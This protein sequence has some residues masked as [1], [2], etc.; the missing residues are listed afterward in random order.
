MKTVARSGGLLSR[1][2]SA[3]WSPAAPVQAPNDGRQIRSTPY[4]SAFLQLPDKLTPRQV[5]Q[6]LRAALAGD[7]MQMN[8]L[9]N[10]MMRSW[11]MLRKC[12]HELRE[13]CSNTRFVV[14]PYSV[15]KGEAPT[16]SA[17]DKADLIRRAMA[18]FAPAQDDSNERGWNG[19]IYDAG[20]AM[21][22]GI[23]T[24]ELL[25]HPPM[26]WGAG[27]EKLPRAAC[28]ANPRHFTFTSDGK[29]LLATPSVGVNTFAEFTNSQTAGKSLDPKS[30]VVG[31]FKS[32]SGSVLAEGF[33]APLALYWAAMKF[34][35]EPMLIAAQN[36]GAPYVD[37]T[38]AQGMSLDQIN[39]LIDNIEKGLSNRVIAH[40]EGSVVTMS[41]GAHAASQNPQMDIVKLSDQYCCELLL[42]TEATT[43]KST[44]TMNGD[45]QN[46]PQDK[47]KNER[48]RGLANWCS[49]EFLPHFV[50][51]VL[52]QNY[53]TTA[54]ALVEKPTIEPDFTQPLTAQ[55]KGM[56]MT[57]LAN[58]K[59]PL[60]IEDYYDMVGA[61]VPEEG[62]KVIN[63]STGEIG[64]IGSTEED[65]DVSQVQPP[66][67]P[68]PVK[69]DENN[70]PIPAM[71]PEQAHGVPP[72]QATIRAGAPFGNDNA[73]KNHIHEGTG[74]PLNSDGTV[75]LYHGTTAAGEKAIKSDGGL[76]GKEDGVFLTTH[77][78]SIGYGDKVVSVK[79][80]P[81]KLVLDDEFPDGRKDFRIPAKVGQLVP[82]K[83]TSST[84]LRLPINRILAKATPEEVGQIIPILNAAEIA[85]HRNGE[86]AELTKKLLEIQNR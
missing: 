6:I 48:V 26:D 81:S 79:V 14:K 85:V 60:T 73:A 23:S 47:T 24:T 30:F 39:N 25:F 35:Y 38:H 21:L 61:S 4:D 74:L 53:G 78:D 63:P 11:P 67:P 57:A 59:T 45:S 41:P 64:L 75:T 54:A 36:F 29:L 33:I 9:S 17:L 34:C 28:W 18:N 72:V 27:I 44:N 43:K 84:P 62:D 52:Y 8:R 83:L 65:Y 82:V 77:P 15:G 20:D 80:D 22:G 50:E 16:K 37:V 2:K 7:A 19:M 51:A 1:I 55:E 13:P 12:S 31:K 68:V 49:T 86:H 69:L 42:G 40:V 76:R 71:T 66:A 5:L 58:C 10:L 70:N 46:S 3:I 32:Q 56:V